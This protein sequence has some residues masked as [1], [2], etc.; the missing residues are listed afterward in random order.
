MRAPSDPPIQIGSKIESAGRGQ[1]GGRTA[2]GRAALAPHPCSVRESSRRRT[3]SDVRHQRCPGPPLVSS[4]ST[5]SAVPGSSWHV[6]RVT[7]HCWTLIP[8]DPRVR[9]RKRAGLRES[10]GRRATADLRGEELKAVR[11]VRRP[12][13]LRISLFPERVNR[14]IEPVSGGTSSNRGASSVSRP[15]QQSSVL[16]RRSGNRTRL[17]SPDSAA[18]GGLLDSQPISDAWIFP[19]TSKFEGENPRTMWREGARPTIDVR[20]DQI[21]GAVAGA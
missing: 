19:R 6:E 7:D 3:R 15:A 9:C 16:A 18:I 12:R 1:P 11:G 17:A 21:D 20:L 8:L 14:R 10:T 5:V 4:V 13:S 2:S